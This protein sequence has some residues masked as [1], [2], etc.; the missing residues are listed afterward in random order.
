MDT[1]KLNS[2]QRQ[3]RSNIRALFLIA[4]IEEMEKAKANYDAFGQK[5]LEEMIQTCKDQ[6]VT[7]HGKTH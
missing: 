6:G 3:Q 1:S 7:D 4:S 5:V 2:A